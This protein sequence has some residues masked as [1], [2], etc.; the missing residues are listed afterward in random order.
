MFKANLLSN[1]T[2]VGSKTKS[3][4]YGMGKKMDTDTG[5]DSDEEQQNSY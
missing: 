3:R 2:S 1:E 4:S 5:Y